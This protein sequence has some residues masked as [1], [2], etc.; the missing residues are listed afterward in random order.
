MGGAGAPSDLPLA[1]S[2]FV[3]TLVMSIFP[4]TLTDTDQG[5]V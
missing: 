5:Q 1:T 3:S 2:V 4:N